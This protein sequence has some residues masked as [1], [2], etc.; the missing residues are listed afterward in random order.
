MRIAN[1]ESKLLWP[2]IEK[3]PPDILLSLGTGHNGQD[4][5]GYLES[6]LYDKRRLQMRADIAM[7]PETQARRWNFANIIRPTVTQWLS[8][9]FNRVDNI[10]DSEQIWRG[11]RSDVMG[12]SG[13]A[14]VSRYERINPNIG[15]RPPKLD[16]KSQLEP[17]QRAVKGKLSGAPLQSKIARIANRLVASSFY[18]EKLSAPKE[19]NMGYICPSTCQFGS[20]FSSGINLVNTDL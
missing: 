2:D 9:L 8:I 1:Y 11:F 17:I 14:E 19:E 13:H 15:F 7:P 3:H 18:L 10:L 5:E 6:Q 20:K 16:Q 4:T 12:A